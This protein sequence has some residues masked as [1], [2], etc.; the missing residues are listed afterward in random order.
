MT[1]KTK[2]VVVGTTLLMLW[3]F[4]I[5]LVDLGFVVEV[6]AGFAVG[7]FLGGYCKRLWDK[8]DSYIE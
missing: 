6:V 4:F 7:W 1:N 5:L 8:E 3:L 2:A